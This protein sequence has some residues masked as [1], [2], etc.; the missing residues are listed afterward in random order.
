MYKIKKTT[1]TIARYPCE[2]NKITGRYF[3]GILWCTNARI[4]LLRRTLEKIFLKIQSPSMVS[5]LRW[6]PLSHRT[7]RKSPCSRVQQYCHLHAAEVSL[8]P[9]RPLVP[10]LAALCTSSI[11][12]HGPVL[13]P[14]KTQT[15]S[16]ATPLGQSLWSHRT[17]LRLSGRYFQRYRHRHA[18]KASSMHQRLWYRVWLLCAHLQYDLTGQASHRWERR[19]HQWQHCLDNVCGQL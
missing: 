8:L 19:L 15:P 10:S 9:Q 1:K 18:V 7:I 11:G 14:V 6:C 2:G 13:A 17:I 16:M 4:R 12:Y 3:N 5:P